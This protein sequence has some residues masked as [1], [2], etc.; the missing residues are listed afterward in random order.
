[1]PVSIGAIAWPN[2]V[3]STCK[4]MDTTQP[5]L[6]PSD[7]CSIH[8]VDIFG[9][10]WSMRQCGYCT[11]GW[12]YIS[13]S[14]GRLVMCAGMPDPVKK[15][16][17]SSLKLLHCSHKDQSGQGP[18][19]AMMRSATQGHHANYQAYCKHCHGHTL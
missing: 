4:Q 8:N 2:G 10:K 14:D 6:P 9:G 17:N 18:T 3:A 19:H 11:R 12:Q 16:A 5:C 13:T 1:M 15:V 7:S